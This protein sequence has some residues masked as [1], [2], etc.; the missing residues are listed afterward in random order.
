MPPLEVRP[1]LSVVVQDVTFRL[2]RH[3]PH[4]PARV[5]T[6]VRALEGH[7][8]D[9]EHDEHLI[10]SLDDV[11]AVEDAVAIVVPVRHHFHEPR[12][13]RVTDGVDVAT[14]EVDAG[15]KLV[16]LLP[17][18]QVAV[19]VVGQTDGNGRPMAARVDFDAPQVRNIE[20]FH[21]L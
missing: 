2:P 17:H 1:Q 14:V 9:V 21:C 18:P 7:G 11:V 19:V 8:V 10:E 15:S 16:V 3:V 6:A 4:E 13:V 20:V 12:K 5:H